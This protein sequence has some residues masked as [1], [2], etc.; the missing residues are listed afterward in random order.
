[1]CSSVNCDFRF[2]TRLL[3]CITCDRGIKLVYLPPYSPDLNPIEECFS[4]VKQ[5]IRRHG[6][7]FRDIVE[8]GDIAA[9]YL[10][11][12]AALDKVTAHASMG[13]FRHSGYL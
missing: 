8:S 1:V 5:Y 6:Q 10:F 11:L 12:Y 7:E 9:P 3:T 2:I 13:W 4:F